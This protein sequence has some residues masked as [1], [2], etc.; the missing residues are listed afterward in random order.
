MDLK[1]LGEYLTDLL[2][3]SERV[4]LPGLG[5]FVSE[6]VPATITSFGTQLNPPSAKTKFSTSETWNDEL[7]ERLYASRE[8]ISLTLAKEEISEQ[9]EQLKKKLTAEKSVTIPGVGTLEYISEYDIRFTVAQGY[10]FWPESIGLESINIKPLAVKGE[11]EN[12]SGKPSYYQ[13]APTKYKETKAKPVSHEKSGGNGLKVFLWI[14]FTLFFLIALVVAS[15]YF[16]DELRP[17][18]EQILYNRE[19]RELLKLI[20]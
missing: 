12:I 1:Q 11:I 13:S 17:L 14:L 18:L 2:Y 16:R 4:S 20:K 9:V 5:S 8:G 7:L 6:E 10:N 19:E 3:T 15:Y